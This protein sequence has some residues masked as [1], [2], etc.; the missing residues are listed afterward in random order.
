M[1]DTG[2]N[3]PVAAVFYRRITRGDFWNI[4]RGPGQGP[5]GGGGQT[6]I[7]IPLGGSL[8]HAGLWRFL[9]VVPPTQLTDPWPSAVTHTA[10]IGDPAATSPVEF[11]HR[12]V[13]GRYRIANQN[14]FRP[15]ANRH[16]AW[17]SARGFPEAPPTAVGATDARM[18]D[19]AGLKV[20][21]VRS[22]DNEYLA[23]FV[24][25]R[26]MPQSWPRGFGLEQLF[27][28]SSAGVIE[29]YEAQ[30]PDMPKLA[31]AIF[32]AWR[33]RPNV[34]LYGPPGT[35]KTHA[36]Q[37]IWGV[38]S[39][40][41]ALKGLV[42][43]PT[44]T[45]TPF[46]QQE[47]E[48]P[49]PM[50][51]HREWVTF[52]QNYSYEH[53]VLALRPESHPG[54]G[55]TLKPKAG[56]LIDAVARTDGSV[57]QAAER[58]AAAAVLF[59]DEVNR[60]NVSRIFGELI[61]FMDVDYR[62]HVRGTQNE[63]A[64]PV[65]LPG[66][67]TQQTGGSSWTEP[68]GAPDGSAITLPSPW[69]FPEPVYMLASMNSVDRAVAPLDSALA[70]QFVRI[71]VAPDLGALADLLGVTDMDVLLATATGEPA[72]SR[73]KSGN[74]TGGGRGGPARSR[75]RRGRAWGGGSRD[76]AGQPRAADRRDRLA[77]AVSAELR[78]RG[79]PRPGL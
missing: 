23:G 7:D 61:T 4:E 67:G 66:V 79:N 17:M 18:P 74:C 78:A 63:L 21:I 30:T 10:V 62:S 37:W 40:K 9:N 73:A 8:S 72:S 76:D 69:L 6:Y 39:G 44:S 33:R 43:D 47:V 75:W 29:L 2:A 56:V 42:L 24:N 11:R 15:G 48:L 20:Y 49:F 25:A 57:Q 27:D 77:P 45:S 31:A 14:R 16:P 41:R 51:A 50:P 19:L 1:A 26:E 54:G 13:N 58:R 52:H 35:G 5:Q 70:R 65:P 53:F 34:L 59:I 3:R 71:E 64:L 60:G 36:M 28:N 46:L 38:L 68:L 55:L 12:Q 32:A 22:T